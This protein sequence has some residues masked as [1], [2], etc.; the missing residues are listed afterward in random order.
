MAIRVLQSSVVANYEVTSNAKFHAGDGLL[1]DATNLNFTVTLSA[2]QTT[3]SNFA[4][5][6]LADHNATSNTMIQADPVGSTVV[7]AD[8]STFTSYGN[9]FYVGPKRAIGDFQDETVQV[10]T[11]LTDT[12]PTPQRGVGT[13]RAH[14]SQFVTDR[15]TI[16]SAITAATPLYVV[17]SATIDTGGKLTDNSSGN[18]VVLARGDFYDSTAGLVYATIVG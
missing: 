14:G 13:L 4:G 12:G 3:A 6:A 16:N 11:N 5:F 1:L 2:T 8:G 9:G 7:S 18:G 17:A 10:V 15:Y